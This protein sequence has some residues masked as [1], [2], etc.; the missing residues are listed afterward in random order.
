MNAPIE[1]RRLMR[2]LGRTVEERLLV[3]PVPGGSFVPDCVGDARFLEDTAHGI[4]L[5]LDRQGVLD[6]IFLHA[7]AHDDFTQYPGPLLADLRFAMARP[8]V[9]RALGGPTSSGAP[10]EPSPG[11]SHGGWDRFVMNDVAVHVTYHPATGA[12]DL[13]TIEPA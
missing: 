13:V 10:S 3:H 2:L 8:E 6:A 12:I 9:V 1:L 7:E 4:A 5:S 11:C